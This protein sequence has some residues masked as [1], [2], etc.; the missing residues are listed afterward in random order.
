MK[1]ILSVGG[2]IV[3]FLVAWTAA[4]GLAWALRGDT[5]PFQYYFHYL[6]AVVTLSGGEIVPFMLVLTTILFVPLALVSVWFV[7]RFV[8][9][10]PT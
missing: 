9:G 2:V 5:I 1:W 8:R 3:S 6:F 4:F 7:H 10:S